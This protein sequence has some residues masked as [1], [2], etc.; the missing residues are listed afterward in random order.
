MYC[1]Y[2]ELDDNELIMQIETELI[3]KLILPFNDKIP[4]KKIGFAV[5]AAGLQ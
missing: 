3:N 1:S 5:K 2:I 4:D